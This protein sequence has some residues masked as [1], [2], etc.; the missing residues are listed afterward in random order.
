M[1]FK[2]QKVVVASNQTCLDFIGKLSWCIPNVGLYKFNTESVVISINRRQVKPKFFLVVNQNLNGS[3]GELCD[4][5]FIFFK[6]GLV[7][8]SLIVILLR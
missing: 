8:A 5:R 4:W 7:D 3:Q 6:N 2:K 1:W